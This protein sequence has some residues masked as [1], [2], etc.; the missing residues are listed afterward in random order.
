MAEVGIGRQ[1][2]ISVIRETES[3]TMT[4][5]VADMPAVANANAGAAP[6][7]EPEL[8]FPPQPAESPMPGTTPKP[9][10]SPLAGIHVSEIPPEHRADLPANIKGVMVDDVDE[11]TPA[12]QVVRPADV[13]EEINHRPIAS[14]AD[15]D[16]TVKT[17]KP[18]DKQMLFI[19]R[20]MDRSFVVIDPR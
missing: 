1:A 18:G 10:T 20:G 12:A 16:A 3:V 9:F 11:D 7:P 6:A 17:L 19:C 13:I 4:V 14:V 15:Y 8:V 2:R 5:G